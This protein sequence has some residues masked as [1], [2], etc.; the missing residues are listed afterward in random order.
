[1]STVGIKE[2]KNRLTHYLRQTKGGGEIVVTERGQAIAVIQPIRSAGRIESR[3][4]KLGRLA[5]RGLAAL[6]TE[7]PLRKVRMVKVSGPAVSRTI[8]EERR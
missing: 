6:P 4:A 3:E 1:M 5:S 2:L 8:L 7:K